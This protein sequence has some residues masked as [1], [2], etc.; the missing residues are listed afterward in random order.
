MTK[1]RR[2]VLY[3][4]GDAALLWAESLERARAAVQGRHDVAVMPRATARRLDCCCRPLD[5]EQ[6]Q[7][8]GFAAGC[9]AGLDC[10]AS[11]AVVVL[12]NPDVIVDEDFFV[13]LAAI[14]WPQDLAAI[15]P[16]V[17]TPQGAIEQSGRAF[18]SVMTGAFGRTS[19]LSRLL[20]DSRLTRSQLLAEPAGRAQ[21]V[22]WVS[23]ACMIAPAERFARVGRLDTRYWMYWE[24]ADWCRRAH[25]VGLRVEYH[26]ELVVIHRQGSS[27]RL[28]PWQTTIACHRS[29]ERYYR[30]HVARSRRELALAD[31]LLA[32]HL[33]VKL[34]AV[35]IRRAVGR[36]RGHDAGDSGYG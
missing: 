20:P 23:G 36:A 26:P 31:S 8:R 15:G 7:N 24:D 34:V 13:R 1:L 14:A 18:P 35:A 30:G 9:N 6:D 28:R 19:L 11:R 3:R 25:D 10:V 16:R 33:I 4:A 27:S 29:A 17:L 22:D 12:L 5:H 32:V 21:T 2:H